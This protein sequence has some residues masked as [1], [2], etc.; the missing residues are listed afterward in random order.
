MTVA[1]SLFVICQDSLCHQPSSCSSGFPPLFKP[2]LEPGLNKMG[3][4]HQESYNYSEIKP[5]SISCRGEDTSGAPALFNITADEEVT[6]DGCDD[7]S[8]YLACFKVKVNMEAI[9]DTD[10]T[11]VALPDGT[12]ASRSAVCDAGDDTGYGCAH[13]N[14]DDHTASIYM[15]YSLDESDTRG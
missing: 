5:H 1:H 9:L 10:I 11:E 4:M 12:I 15:S 14:N 7:S 13:F 6:M 2:L 3:K 8:I